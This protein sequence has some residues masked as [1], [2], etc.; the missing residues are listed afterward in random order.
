MEAEVK[1]LLLENYISGAALLR[2]AG[3]IVR[4][5]QYIGLSLHYGIKFR[6]VKEIIL[7]PLALRRKLK[8]IESENQS[9]YI[10]N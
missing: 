8:S 1:K 10:N 7:L 9:D 4:S 2:K 5:I 6:Q 3:R